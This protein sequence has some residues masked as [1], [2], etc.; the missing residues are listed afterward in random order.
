MG[1]G[2]RDARLIDAAACNAASVADRN[3][4]VC[5]PVVRRSTSQ[6]FLG[7]VFAGERLLAL[8]DALLLDVTQPHA[9]PLVLLDTNLEFTDLAAQRRLGCVGGCR[10]LTRG[11][12][13]LAKP[14]L[15]PAVL[16]DL[17]TEPPAA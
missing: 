9:L 1:L 6:V 5:G 10:L 14:I 13:N 12:E 15:R 4:A 11:N 8:V 7:H 3:G 2:P 16:L 17:L